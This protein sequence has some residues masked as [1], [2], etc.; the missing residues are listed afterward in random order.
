MAEAAKRLERLTGQLPTAERVAGT[1]EARPGGE[2]HRPVSLEPRDGK[3]RH[4]LTEA[5]CRFPRLPSQTC[6][7]PSLTAATRPRTR[8]A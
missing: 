4:A 3:N 2:C 5:L 7:V 1:L 6:R 8:H